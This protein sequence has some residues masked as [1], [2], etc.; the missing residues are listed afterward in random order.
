VIARQLAHALQKAE[1]A[2]RIQARKGT[3]VLDW[4]LKDLA[5]REFTLGAYRGKVIILNFFASW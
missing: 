5:G 2:A 4:K 1:R 3:P